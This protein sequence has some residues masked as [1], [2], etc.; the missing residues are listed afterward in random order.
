MKT[1]LFLCCLFAARLLAAQD[2]VAREQDFLMEGKPTNALVARVEG[3][4]DFLRKQWI[5]FADKELEVKL[6]RDG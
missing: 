6:K 2:I 4:H 3:N 1:Y 5:N